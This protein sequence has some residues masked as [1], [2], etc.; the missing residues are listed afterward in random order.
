MEDARAARSRRERTRGRPPAGARRVPRDR[1]ATAAADENFPVV[2]R[3]TFGRRAR[4]IRAFY[5]FARGADDVADDPAASVADKLRRLD[6]YEASLRRGPESSALVRATSGL[7]Q[8]RRALDAA[9]AL[10]GAFRQD[11]RGAHYADWAA[12][13]AYCAMSAIPVGRFLLAAHDEGDAAEPAADALC[14]ALQ[15]LN[16]LQDLRADRNRLGRVY[17]PA[18]MLAAAGSGPRDLSRSALSPGARRVVDAALDRCDALIARA[19]PLP[20]SIRSRALRAQAAA[21]LHL[22]RRL[23]ARLRDGDPLARRVRPTRADF[24]AAGLRGAAAALRPGP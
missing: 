23:A 3:L 24:A 1:V 15:V 14:T 8:R 4:A 10:L 5:A 22:A 18:D 16:H 21:T 6:R 12:L 11:A 17:L 20:R 9:R 7:A 19:A 13:E 2:G